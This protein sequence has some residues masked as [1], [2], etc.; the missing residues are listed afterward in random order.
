MTDRLINTGLSLNTNSQLVGRKQRCNLRAGDR[1]RL[2]VAVLDMTHST[3][4][5]W[6]V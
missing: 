4:L 5:H 3:V 2:T 6:R 1:G